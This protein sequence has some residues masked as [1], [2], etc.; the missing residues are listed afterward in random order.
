MTDL[1]TSPDQLYARLEALGIAVTH[2]EHPP[3]H[4]VEESKALRGTLPGGHVKN[5][6]LRDKKST[7]WLVVADEDRAID[8]KTLRRIIGGKGSLS[9]GRPELLLEV[10]GVQP[11]AVTPFSLINDTDR[12]VNVVLDKDFMAH[13]IVN[14]HPL[15][16][17]ATTA[18]RSAD[19]LTFIK[20][21]GHQPEILDLD[22]APEKAGSG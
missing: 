19:L 6:F 11:G 9:F 7:I 2:H 20:A 12:R 1:P 10:L 17:T 14:C 4:T 18:I 13:E 8:M 22:V 15:V 21:C 16:N 3:L 5:L